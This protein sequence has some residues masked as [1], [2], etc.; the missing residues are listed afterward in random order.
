MP[1]SK[2]AD[3]TTEARGLKKKT[4][5]KKKEGK[6]YPSHGARPAGTGG[7]RPKSRDAPLYQYRSVLTNFLTHM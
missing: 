4:G 3:P 1:F 2:I 5:D 7:I 6:A